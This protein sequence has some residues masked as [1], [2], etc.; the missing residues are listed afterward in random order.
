[1]KRCKNIAELEYKAYIEE[2]RQGKKVGEAITDAWKKGAP[3]AFMEYETLRRHISSR[4]KHG[5]YYSVERK[6]LRAFLDVIYEWWLKHR[7]AVGPQY[8]YAFWSVWNSLRH[9]H[10]V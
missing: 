10:G 4:Y 3:K 7:P 9:G 6:D 2:L 1:M 8:I 5:D